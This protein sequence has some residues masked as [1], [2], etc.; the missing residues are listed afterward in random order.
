[1]KALI[2]YTKIEKFIVY[3]DIT[4]GEFCKNAG[5]SYSTLKNVEKEK[6]IAVSSAQKIA[7]AMHENLLSILKEK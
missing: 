3:K 5:I 7:L 1:M 2:D 4:K 6:G